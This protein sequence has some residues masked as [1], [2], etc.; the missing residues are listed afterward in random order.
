MTNHWVDIKNAD[1]VLIMGGNAAEAH[2]CGFKWVTEA[3]AHNKAKLIVVDPR[4][5]RSA[6]VADYYAP[7]R[8]GTDI[9]FL[10]GLI[11]YLLTNDKIQHDYVVNYTDLPFI[12][13][14]EFAFTDGIYSGYNVDKRSYDRSSWDY[15]MGADGYAKVDP[16][17]KHPRCVYNLLK[18]HY[19]RYVPE[20][21]SRVCGTPQDKVLHVW[22][23]IASTAAPDRAM[24]IMYAL[25]WTQHS[26]GSQMIR[27]GAMVQLLLGNIGVSGGG[28]NALRGHSNI[29]GLTD[30][31]L[32]SDQLPSYISLPNEGEQE[33]AKYIAKRTLK[34]LRPNQ[35]SYWQNTPK[36]FVSFMKTWWGDAA[37]A[38]NNWAYDY[39]P[40]L[41]KLYDM[42]QVYELM[43]QGKM[44]GYI[45]QGFNPLAAAPNKAK[46]SAAFSKL[47]FLVI[48][49]PLATETS[50]FW[51]NY[52]EHNDVDSSKIQTEVFRLPTTCFAEENGALVNSARWLQWHWKG[53]NPPGEARSDLEIM[54][55]IFTRMRAM[56]A[57]DGGAF[58]DPILNLTWKYAQVES[59]SP[60]ELAKEYSGSALK[61]L[62]DPKD[63]TKITRKAGE[64]LA[65][66]AE[67]RDDGST[68]SGCWIYCGAWGPTGNLMARRDNSDPTGIGQT[69]N[70][71]WSW[72][73]NRRV[74]YNRASCDPAGKP[75]NPKRKLIAWNGTAWGGADVPDFKADENPAGGMGPFIMN[76][77]GVARFFARASMAEG[78]FPEHYEPFDTPL[79]YNPLNPHQPQAT[80]NPAARVFAGDREAF[81]KAAEFPH[82]ATTYRLT[83]HFHYW[84]KHARLNSILQPEQFVE[85]GE[86]LAKDI[87]IVTGER[88]KV[89]SNRGYIKAVAMVTKRI[90]ALTV[91]GKT[92]HI[93]GVP[94]HWGF[95]G[96]AKPGFL[97]NTL[98]PA[99]GDANSQTPEFKAFLV[100]VEKA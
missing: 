69:L 63:P 75:Y 87:G 97:A 48:M 32:L 64:Q 8:P 3:K 55:G 22:E 89:S 27:T 79:G 60:E 45:A 76:P 20:M 82:V 65:G 41:D 50:E 90:R 18:A 53:A 77:E 23:M 96:V 86:A 12:V 94:I 61:D 13:K 42:L 99:V 4:F 95:M 57:K 29:Q 37:T 21:V 11:N 93:V 58:P 43:H 83:E 15:E 56:Y 92:L 49:D 51:R 34:P 14:E 19:A 80:N 67:L 66:F 98:T 73:A 7:I 38:Q 78:P 9:T 59:P 30:L 6:S 70:W 2:P 71:A 81:G 31:G 85:I 68:Q 44:N 25:G 88:V 26:I 54:A 40:K 16:T 84:T 28:M 91:D 5:T 100:K 35:L 47:K 33:Y 24:T 39:L 36:F 52:G 17:L 10:G 62:A 72:P 1:L 74:L 46:N